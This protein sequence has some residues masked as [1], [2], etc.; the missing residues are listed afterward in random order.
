MTNKFLIKVFYAVLCLL[1]GVDAYGQKTSLVSQSERVVS[2]V[3]DLRLNSWGH[4]ESYSLEGDWLFAWEI[5]LI[6]KVVSQNNHGTRCMFQAHGVKI[7][8][9]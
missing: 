4:G 6:L 8:V 7:K 5:L 9:S 1:I 3:I 2:D